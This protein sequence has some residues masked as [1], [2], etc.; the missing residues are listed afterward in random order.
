M[1]HFIIQSNHEN[2]FTTKHDGISSKLIAKQWGLTL[3]MV[4]PGGQIP[5][6]WPKMDPNIGIMQIT[7]QF[8][9]FDNAK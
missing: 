6:F 1:D 2:T 8:G 7:S 9:P 3:Y 4:T 5:N